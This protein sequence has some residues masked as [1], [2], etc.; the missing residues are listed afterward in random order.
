MNSSSNVVGVVQLLRGVNAVILCM[1][2]VVMK[3]PL[4]TENKSIFIYAI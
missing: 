2:V 3:S 1:I 4:R